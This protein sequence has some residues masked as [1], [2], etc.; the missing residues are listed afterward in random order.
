MFEGFIKLF[1]GFIAS[2]WIPLL[3]G[4]FVQC[5]QYGI[6]AFVFSCIVFYGINTILGLMRK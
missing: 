2:A 6:A 4:I 1:I 3:V 5:E